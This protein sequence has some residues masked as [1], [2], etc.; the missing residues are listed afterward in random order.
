MSSALSVGVAAS[1]PLQASGGQPPYVYSASGLPPGLTL[2]PATGVISGLPNEAGDFTI[3]WSVEDSTT[4]TA[5]D[6]FLA[7]VQ[8][9]PAAT[10][11]YSFQERGGIVW[12]WVLSGVASVPEVQQ[13]GIVWPWVVGGVAFSTGTVSAQLSAAAASVGA[14]AF[15]VG[16]ISVALSAAA[17]AVSATAGT[18]SNTKLLLNF[19]GSNGQTSYT[20]E[21]VYARSLTFNSGAQI[22]S[23]EFKFG[24]TSLFVPSGSSGVTI[25]STADLVIGASDFTF[26]SWIWFPSNGTVDYLTIFDSLSA[27]GGVFFALYRDSLTANLISW[28]IDSTGTFHPA[29]DGGFSNSSAPLST[30]HHFAVTR[31][32]GTFRYFFN[33]VLTGTA[34]F[35]QEIGAPSAANYVI[36]RSVL[37][38][39]GFLDGYLDGMRLIVGQ[40]LYTANFTP[41]TSPPEVVG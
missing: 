22:S 6:E 4:E 23:A 21:D 7:R 14:V 31:E 36:G 32:S 18:D 24:A 9:V 1:I 30:W 2:D 29:Q 41:P 15:S 28:F 37:N 34:S 3:T 35:P 12:G 13:G 39:S 25:P 5:T 26:E 33:G 38:D 8:A 27:G 17:A 10:P 20:S 40:A 11:H 16:E 19:E